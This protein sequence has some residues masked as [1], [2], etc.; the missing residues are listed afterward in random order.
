VKPET[1]QKIIEEQ[2]KASEVSAFKATT[3]KLF[4]LMIIGVSGAVIVAS[5]MKKR[6]A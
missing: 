4:S 3:G 5:I 1:Y 6:P 2:V